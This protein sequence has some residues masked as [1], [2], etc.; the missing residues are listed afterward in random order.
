MAVVQVAAMY[1]SGYRGIYYGMIV[2]VLAYALLYRRAWILVLAAVGAI[3]LLPP[4]FFERFVS[5][6]DT[7]FADSS[8]FDRIQ[9][10]QAALDVISD[11][12][13]FGVGWGGSGYVHSDLLQLAA[14]LGLPALTVFVAWFFSMARQLFALARRTTWIAPYGAGLFAAICSLFV[15]S[16]GEGNIVWIQLM[17]P[18]WFLFAMTYR[19]FEF[20][21]AEQTG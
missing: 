12:P 10:I 14:N 4:Q 7:R 9:K 18:I 11:S 17:V 19:L 8:Q 15:V 21:Q 16:A 20:G 3:P 2:F 13:F 5:L 6:I 1:L